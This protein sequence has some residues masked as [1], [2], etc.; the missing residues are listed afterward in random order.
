[1]LLVVRWVFHL[2]TTTGMRVYA[3]HLEWVLPWWPSPNFGLQKEVAGWL[4]EA[5]QQ[6]DCE[7]IE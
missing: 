1:L 5:V 2:I 3:W 4:R 6:N 7:Y